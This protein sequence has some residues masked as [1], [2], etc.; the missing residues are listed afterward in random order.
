MMPFAM[1]PG[2]TELILILVI[3]VMV[4]G[5][6]RIPEIMGGL[7]EGIKSFK[8]AV[9]GDDTTETPTP[10]V[11]A[12]PPSVTAEAGGQTEPASK[13]KTDLK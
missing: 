9:E 3:V 12:P 13:E 7:G 1:I 11:T 8:K 5:A 10:Q 2:P 4:F 6:K